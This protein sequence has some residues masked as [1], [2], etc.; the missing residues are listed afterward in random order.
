M[1]LELE[2]KLA[3][4][5]AFARARAWA[6]AVQAF[7]AVLVLDPQ[8]AIA[9][10]NLGNVRDE[11]GDRPS[12]IAAYQQALILA[13]DYDNAKKNLAI[14]AH[15]HGTACYAQGDL[16]SARQSFELAV[17]QQPA[18]ADYDHS[19]L[20]LLLET[21]THAPL[22][23]HTLHMQAATEADS[24]YWPHPYPLLAAV[25]APLWHKEAAKRHLARLCH[26]APAITAPTMTTPSMAAPNDVARKI[27]IAYLSSDWHQHPVPQQLLPVLEAHDTT[28]FEVFGIATDAA[29][30]TSAWR[31]R[32]EQAFDQFLPLGHLT[33]AQIAEQ[34]RAAHIDIAIDLSLY[35]EGGRPLILAHRPCPVQIAFLGYAGTSCA[36]W[37]DYVI[38]DNTVIPPELEAHHSERILR[39]PRS[40][41]PDHNERPAIAMPA[42]APADRAARRIQHGL[43]ADGFVFCAFNNPY[44]ISPQMLTCW[45]EL[46]HAV[47]HSVL[48][49]QANNPWSELNLKRAALQ[50][51]LPV[52]RLV[53]AKRVSSFA[54]HLARYPLADLF[55]DTFPYNAHVTAADALWAGLPVLT[56]QGQSFASRVASSILTALGVP[57]LITT[58][59][60]DYRQQAR[61]LAVQPERLQALAQ[62]VAMGKV[63]SAYFNA[64][65]YV[66]ELEAAFM[67]VMQAHESAE[68]DA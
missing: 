45:F 25:D 56:L 49:L 24:G 68:L 53:F 17:R 3:E 10:N 1:N 27:R 48:W 12:A 21:C 2:N 19:Y 52:Q 54:D 11:L 30:D 14:V 32:I 23:G 40:F 65:R 8:H 67:T 16:G 38:A 20:Q 9:W 50:A 57:E 5:L 6:E 64:G 41:M 43:P 44:K 34:L 51:G 13:P 31:L 37:L 62:R 7:E 4:G 35:M 63:D 59:L 66:R 60:A 46:L 61:E 55:I 26:E 15:Q 29:A 42:D 39:L 33:D 36:P 28:R 47:P 18:R 58:S 22:L